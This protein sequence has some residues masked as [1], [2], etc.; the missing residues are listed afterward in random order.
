MEVMFILTVCRFLSSFFLSFSL[1]SAF[2]PRQALG[3]EDEG[4]EGVSDEEGESDSKTNRI[5]S[6][7]KMIRFKAG[8]VGSEF[9]STS[10]IS[11]SP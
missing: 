5:A 9:P 10:I 3:V 6:G 8:V 11:T 4:S 1:S 7:L 2:H